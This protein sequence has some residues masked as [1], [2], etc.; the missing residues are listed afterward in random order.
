MTT[1]ESATFSKLTHQNA[2]STR[3]HYF[4][5]S[6]NLLC[7]PD[8]LATLGKHDKDINFTSYLNLN[9]F[10]YGKSRISGVASFKNYSSNNNVI[11]NSFHKYNQD[12]ICHDPNP[13]L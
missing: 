9:F 8:L 12:S 5:S 13:T 10:D 1:I 6:I 2:L 3:L 7:Y 11:L 4:C